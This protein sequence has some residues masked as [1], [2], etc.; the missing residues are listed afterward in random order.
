MGSRSATKPAK[1]PYQKQHARVNTAGIVHQTADGSG[2]PVAH[3]YADPRVTHG[4]EKSSTIHTEEKKRE[5]LQKKANENDNELTKE[6]RRICRE[7][8]IQAN[9]TVWM[10]R[11]DK[12][13][14]EEKRG[15]L[16][17]EG[18]RFLDDT[19]GRVIRK[20]KEE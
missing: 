12:H 1:T 7:A 8:M 11:Y 18:R 16:S 10:R 5:D 9:I 17:E 20:E 6:E 13:I 15:E 4:S 19:R 3:R 2:T 14:E